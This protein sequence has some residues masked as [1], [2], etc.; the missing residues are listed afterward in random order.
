MYI[1]TSN[2][3]IIEFTDP[4]TKTVVMIFYDIFNGRQVD[5]LGSFPTV[6]EDGCVGSRDQ[7]YWDML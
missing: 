5:A 2:Q 7:A 4:H 6:P 1:N 3:Y